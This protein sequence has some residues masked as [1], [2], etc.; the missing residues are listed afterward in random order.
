MGISIIAAMAENRVIGRDNQL[1]WRL[2]ADLRHFRALTIGKP[3]IMGRKTFES[4]GRPLPGRDSIVVTRQAA[5]RPA[6]AFTAPD[7]AGA[8]ELAAEKARARGAL[9]IMIAGGAQIY[10]QA[11][12]LCDRLY[13]TEVDLEPDGDAWFPILPAG[14]WREVRR[15]SH[16]EPQ[17]EGPPISYDT[18]VF[19]RLSGPIA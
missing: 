1:P 12:P 9:E 16:S 2:P 18:V 14:E 19:E 3:V 4:I 17:A 6:G 8:L 13:I 5:F 15:D 11:L 7:L 10:A